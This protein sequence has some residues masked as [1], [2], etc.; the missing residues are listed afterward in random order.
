MIYAGKRL[1]YL[2]WL[3]NTF[4]F[5]IGEV[6]TIVVA[7]CCEGT[8]VGMFSLLHIIVMDKPTLLNDDSSLL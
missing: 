7:A 3:C 1:L 8:A 4:L 5:E 6:S 2:S